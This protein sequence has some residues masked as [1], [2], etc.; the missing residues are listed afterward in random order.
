LVDYIN[1]PQNW[2]DTDSHPRQQRAS[3]NV[4]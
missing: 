2:I 4:G 1:Q 3:V